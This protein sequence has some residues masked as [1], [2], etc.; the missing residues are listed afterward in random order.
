MKKFTYLT[1][2]LLVCSIAYSQQQAPQVPVANL[3]INMSLEERAAQSDL[4]IEGKV[5]N[6]N[7]YR[8]N[9]GEMIYTSNI[10]EVYKVFKGI[11]QSETIEVVTIGGVVDDTWIQVEPSLQLELGSTCV[12]MCSY[13]D[14][15][16]VNFM[17]TAK[18]NKSTLIGFNYNNPLGCI[19]YNLNDF[20]ASDGLN[21]YKDINTEVYAKLESL[22]GSKSIDFGKFDYNQYM[23]EELKSRSTKAAPAITSITPTSIPAGQKQFLTINGSGF[24]ASRTAGSSTTYVS[25]YNP[26]DGGATWQSLWDSGVAN[27]NL[28]YKSWSDTKIEVYIIARNSTTKSIWSGTG[29]VRVTASSTSVTSSQTLTIPYAS[30]EALTTIGLWPAELANMNGSGGYTWHPYTDIAG[31]AN[32]LACFTRSIEK[33]SCE[34]HIN[35]VVGSTTTTSTYGQNAECMIR[36]AIPA[37]A[38][39]TNIL[40]WTAT[41]W[42]VQCGTTS[43]DKR[44][45]HAE[46]DIVMNTQMVVGGTTYTWNFTQGNPTSL[47]YDFESVT[48][49][50]LGHCHEIGHVIQSGN[51]MHYSLFN[52]ATARLLGQNADAGDFVVTESIDAA[53]CQGTPSMTAMTLYTPASCSSTVSNNI[54]KNIL[55]RM[56]P[57][58][59]EGHVNIE[60]SPSVNNQVENINV[61]DVLGNNVMKL[62][63]SVDGI[64]NMDFTG[65]SKG[66]Y[67]VKVL[68]NNSDENIMK[69][70]VY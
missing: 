19:K 23:K 35:W 10:I 52:G 3:T 4:I 16:A 55:V 63:N 49:H 42:R 26:Q 40:G 48:T 67:F 18:V 7:S 12:V 13:A 2:L 44:W 61:Y 22:A 32:A 5:I 34:T 54:D 1:M 31:N 64:Y 29:P 15:K 59:S 47:Q 68:F 50:E 6:Q 17:N 14:Q 36:F 38:M 30:Y 53:E 21:V 56:F 24:G 69:L 28:M 27:D 39:P 58:P 11:V 25:F 41:T 37:D 33:W 46:W 60:I 57:N 65:Y 66:V 70:I 8:N 51:L 62:N 9:S 20:V 43:T 45:Y